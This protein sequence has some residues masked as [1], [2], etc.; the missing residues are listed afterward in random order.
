MGRRGE[1][2]GNSQCK[3]TGSKVTATEVTECIPSNDV[4]KEVEGRNAKRRKVSTLP[5]QRFIDPEVSEDQRKG[6]ATPNKKKKKNAEQNATVFREDN[7]FVSFQVEGTDE[8]AE[9]GRIVGN[10]KRSYFQAAPATIFP[11]RKMKKR[12]H[13]IVR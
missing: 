11:T 9:E 13:L 6:E 7:E 12:F 8:F 10:G 2:K 5:N 1:I 4:N 3:S